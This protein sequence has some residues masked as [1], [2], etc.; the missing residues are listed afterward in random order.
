MVWSWQ[1]APQKVQ[2]DNPLQNFRRSNQLVKVGVNHPLRGSTVQSRRSGRTIHLDGQKGRFVSEWPSGL[3]R[4]IFRSND[5]FRGTTH[6]KVW[7][8]DPLQR[9][10]KNLTR[11]KFTRD[12][13]LQ[14][15]RRRNDLIQMIRMNYLP[16]I[17]GGTVHSCNVRRDNLVQKI[18]R[19]VPDD[20]A[21][22][23]RS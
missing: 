4:T 16:H 6:C 8:D 17:S 2:R 15:S 10:R 3:E 19:D 22:N 9:F 23:F 1:L 18:W 21:Q 5:L 11:Q 14:N 20:P 12:K 7:R 13:P